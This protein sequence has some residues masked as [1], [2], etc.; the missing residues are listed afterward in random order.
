MKAAAE[1]GETALFVVS[2]LYGYFDRDQELMIGPIATWAREQ[3]LKT[4]HQKRR[5]IGSDDYGA[6]VFGIRWN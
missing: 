6:E 1:K 5:P 4:F 3:G 2:N